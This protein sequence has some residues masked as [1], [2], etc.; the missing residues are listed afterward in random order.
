[1][2]AMESIFQ[3]VK[4]CSSG[5][6]MFIITRAV[7]SVDNSVCRNNSSGVSI[8]IGCSAN[9]SGNGIY[10]NRKHGIL[11]CGKGLIKENDVFCNALSQWS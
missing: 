8:E 2:P 7:V 3:V 6:T 11:V 10:G 5:V 9:V 1:M 4:A